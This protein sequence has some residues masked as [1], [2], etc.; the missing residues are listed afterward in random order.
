M[1]K[2]LEAFRGFDR[3]LLDA[4][5]EIPNAHVS[6]AEIKERVIGIE[7]A[8]FAM[9]EVGV[10]K[11]VIIKMLQKYWDLRLSEATSFVEEDEE[12]I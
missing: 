1:N 8:T 10:E 3:E 7:K 9:L 4:V 12:N 5:R 2:F 11:E 6:E